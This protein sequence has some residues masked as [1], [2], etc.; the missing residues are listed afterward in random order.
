MKHQKAECLLKL[1]LILL[2]EDPF[3]RSSR[4]TNRKIPTCQ[5][6]FDTRKWEKHCTGE[7]KGS[8][9]QISL[10]APLFVDSRELSSISWYRSLRKAG[11]NCGGAFE[12]MT[13]ILAGIVSKAAN[14][15][16][17]PYQSSYTVHPTT[18]DICLQLLAL[19]CQMVSLADS[20]GLL[21]QQ[22][23]RHSRSSRVSRA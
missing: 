16:I 1:G 22:V 20:T 4:L 11:L 13:K 17:E 21:C 3:N 10:V 23:Y 18:V 5:H 8:S 15:S 12:G 6:Y 14:A 9:D 2:L 19:L 7:I